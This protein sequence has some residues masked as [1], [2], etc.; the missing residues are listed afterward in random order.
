MLL[1]LL[2]LRLTVNFNNYDYIIISNYDEIVLFFSGIRKRCFLVNHINV[3]ELNSRIKRFFIKKVSNVHTQIVFEEYMKLRFNEFGIND[4]VVVKHGLLPPY[5]LPENYLKDIEIID[6]RLIDKEYDKILFSPST[7]SSD[8]LFN[9]L[10]IESQDFCN[11]IKQNKILFVVKDKY[12]SSSFAN[13]LVLNSYISNSQY[14]SILLL[15]YGVLISYSSSFEYRIS[16]VLNE[17]ISN[18]KLCFMSDIV[19]LKIYSEN[20]LYK[21]YFSSV[22]ELILMIKKSLN[23]NFEENTPKYIG[24][25]TFKPD[26][27]SLII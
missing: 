1:R 6:K 21:Y 17:C 4:V 5:V 15:S 14:Q 22:E 19:A 8:P 26:F 2:F 25:D 10:L 24:V 13:I 23:N 7:T 16:N 12:L 9:K 18:N 20:I 3:S 11:F 27:T